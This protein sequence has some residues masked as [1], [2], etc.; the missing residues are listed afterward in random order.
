MI[1]PWPGKHK[2]HIS[3]DD[4][5]T[6][7]QPREFTNLEYQGGRLRDCSRSSFHAE[8]I[9]TM[10]SLS[11][12]ILTF[13]CARNPI[14]VETFASHLFDALPD[15][16]SIDQQ[17]SLTAPAIIVLSL[18]EIAPIAYA[19][20][21]GSFLESYFDSFRRAVDLA[22]AERWQRHAQYVNIAKP[23]CGLTGIMVFVRSDAESS[24][25]RVETAEAGLG[26][27]Q[28][29]NKS[30][31][32]VRLGYRTAGCID[33]AVGLT[34]VA[35]HLAPTEY[36]FEHR[37]EDWRRIVE[38]L[39][40]LRDGA[41]SRGVREEEEEDDLTGLLETW[42]ASQSRCSGIFSPSSHLFLAGD[43]NYRTSDSGPRENDSGRF[44]QPTSDIQNPWHYSRLLRD[45]Q[46]IRE[47]EAQKT[48]HGL[49]EAPI[50]FPPTYKYSLE[51]RLDAGAGEPQEWKWE[52]SRWPSW[53][54]RILYLDL[55]PGVEEVGH[56]QPHVY[57]A[58]PL[59]P[60]SDHRAVVLFVSVPLKSL[61]PLRNLL[62]DEDVRLSTPFPL[63][64][65]WERKRTAARTAEVIV[66]CLAYLGLTK[67][68]NGLLLATSIGALGGWLMLRFVMNS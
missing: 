56:I 48:L 57:Q 17:G 37:N 54:D 60:S 28:M 5:P 26:F 65:D 36:A 21:G 47:V 44:P 6:T 61:W 43:L 33:E 46:L 10:E 23:N 32:G 25:S 51:A 3:L 35:A 59:F 1:T 7:S 15:S 42:T 55:P 38:R 41:G 49:S 27:L 20:L 66:G 22:A 13:N 4:H 16:P 40:F 12:Y 9:A 53:C 50:T 11:L 2:Q 30:A 14:Q 34:F 64:K 29:G 58:L 68:G 62:R 67:E 52:K 8:H 24:I 45:D 31:V 18:Q 19:F 63:D 39:V